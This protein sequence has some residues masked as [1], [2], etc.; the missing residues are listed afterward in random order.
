MIIFISC[1]QRINVHVLH[2]R[3]RKDTHT[4]TH[5]FVVSKLSYTLAGS[6]SLVWAEWVSLC[7]RRSLYFLEATMPITHST[8][9]SGMSLGYENCLSKA[10]L[11]GGHTR[12]SVAGN[13]SQPSRLQHNLDGSDNNN[14]NSSGRPMV[15]VKMIKR[16]N[17]M[18]YGLFACE[19]TMWTCRSECFPIYSIDRQKWGAAAIKSPCKTI[20]V[21]C[22]ASEWSIN[23]FGHILFG[24][25]KMAKPHR[26]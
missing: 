21:L 19:M 26:I 12:C 25:Y 5:E 20:E 14:H 1:F 4:C 9:Q 10:R 17:T 18:W 22:S 6:E 2:E 13:L 16:F 23:I 7:V 24:C 3:M 8:H 15:L 11:Y